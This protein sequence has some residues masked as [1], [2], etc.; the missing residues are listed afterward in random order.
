MAY[1][2]CEG[3]A[4][5]D[6]ERVTALG[7]RLFRCRRC[8]RTVNERTGTPFTYLQVPTNIVLLVVL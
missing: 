7:Y 8:R 5:Q 6:L 2:Y 4:T 1:P 3:D